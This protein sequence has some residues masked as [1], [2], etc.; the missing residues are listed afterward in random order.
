MSDSARTA[1]PNARDACWA[2]A[3]ELHDAGADV[4]EVMLTEGWSPPLVIAATLKLRR[5]GG[6]TPPP[7][8]WGSR[9]GGGNHP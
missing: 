9:G 1:D 6:S 2:R 7:V 5:L 3:L 4:L 8:P